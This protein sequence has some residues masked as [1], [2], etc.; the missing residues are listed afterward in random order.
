[1][2]QVVPWVDALSFAEDVS[3]D[4]QKFIVPRNNKCESLETLPLL[5]AGSPATCFRL[6][7]LAALSRV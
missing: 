2:C 5:L 3:V 7:I 6:S 4:Q 1:M